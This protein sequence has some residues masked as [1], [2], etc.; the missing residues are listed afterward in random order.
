MGNMRAG[1]SETR[2]HIVQ[3]MIGAVALAG[4]SSIAAPLNSEGKMDVGGVR[5][6]TV[7]VG[8]VTVFYREAGVEGRPVLLL[9]H[10]FANSS[11]YFRHLMPLL[12][13]RFHLVAPD[14]PSFGFTRVDGGDYRYTFVQ[15]TETTQ[16]FVDALGLK[17]FAMYVFDYGAPIGFNLAVADPGRITA[18][19]S[20]NGNAYE[21]GLGDGPW[22][23]LRAYWKQPSVA[24]REQIK[25]RMSLDG[26]RESYFQGVPDVS[27]IEPE[28]YWLDA[29]L[30]AQPGMM[31]LQVDL[32]LD[33]KANLERYPLYQQYL[34]THRPPLLAIWGKN[35]S[36]FIPPGA[37]AFRRDVP[38]AVVQL[39]DAGHFALETNVDE[40]ASAIL[41]FM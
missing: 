23:P 40:I 37:E 22:A 16:G 15:L 33:Y 14:L 4:S 17:R 31:E 28:A 11:H 29:A 12:A 19:I 26:V 41:N 27:R 2:R 18:I 34:R 7:K 13:N 35:D 6:S 25:G 24:I 9:L 30:L 10:G 21:E 8:P 1:T 38:D 3:G 36:F 32:K 5:H 39:L 20:Q